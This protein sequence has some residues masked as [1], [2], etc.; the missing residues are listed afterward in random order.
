[1]KTWLLLL[2]SVI[3]PQTSEKMW[4]LYE[5]TVPLFPWFHQHSIMAFIHASDVIQV[6]TFRDEIML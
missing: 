6:E 5:I 2:N 3:P 1:M 4:I